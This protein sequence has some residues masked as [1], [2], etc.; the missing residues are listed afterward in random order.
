MRCRFPRIV[1]RVDQMRHRG[2]G[3]HMGTGAILR[4][5]HLRPGRGQR[6]TVGVGRGLRTLPE[7][8]PQMQAV[9]ENQQD[10]RFPG[11]LSSVRLRA[12]CQA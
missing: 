4:A 5:F 10:G 8:Q 6:Q 2:T 3:S 11:M 1:L 12:R 7:I 9:R